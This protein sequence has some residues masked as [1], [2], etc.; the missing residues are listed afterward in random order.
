MAE[1]ILSSGNEAVAWGAIYAGC[2]YFFGYPI[3]PQNEI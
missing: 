1:K 3:T 2:K